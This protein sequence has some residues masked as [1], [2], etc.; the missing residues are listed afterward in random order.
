LSF[1]QK[2]EE[3]TRAAEIA[4]E[5]AKRLVELGMDVFMVFDS[6]TRLA[7]PTICNTNL[8]RTL[9]EVLTRQLCTRQ[10][11]FWSSQKY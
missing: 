9:W 8:G 10:K 5:R 1:D 6:I 4:I 7:R 3:Q 2:P 11:D